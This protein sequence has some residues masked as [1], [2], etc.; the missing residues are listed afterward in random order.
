[1]EAMLMAFITMNMNN[2]GIPS[3]K[4]NPISRT[5]PPLFMIKISEKEKIGE[6]L[7]KIESMQLIV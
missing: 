1:M 4:A 6:D 3:T 2:S 7:H 5:F